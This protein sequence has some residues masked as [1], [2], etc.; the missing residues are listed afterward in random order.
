MVG[1][2]QSGEEHRYDYTGMAYHNPEYTQHLKFKLRTVKAENLSEDV[3]QGHSSVVHLPRGGWQRKVSYRWAAFI[4]GIYTGS[5]MVP[6]VAVSPPNVKGS[7]KRRKSV[8]TFKL[9]QLMESSSCFNI[10]I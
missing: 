7:A 2:R 4:P 3:G 5:G 9:V 8:E 6:W 10:K 1:G